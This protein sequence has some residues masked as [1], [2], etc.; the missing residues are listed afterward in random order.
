MMGQDESAESST[1]TGTVALVGRPNVGKS[2]LLNALLGEKIA[3]TTHKPQTTRRLLRGVL[4]RGDSQFVFVDTP[5]LL[6]RAK[7]LDSFMIEEALEAVRDVDVLALIAEAH[8]EKDADGVVRAV[9]DR[10]DVEALETIERE[11][12]EGQ[13]PV[14]LI[15]NKIDR[16]QDR[17]LLLP[18]IASWSERREFA[19]IIPISAMKRDG[20]SPLLDALA[21]HLPDGP[22]LFAPDTL[23]DAPEREI[24]AELIREKAMLE[25]GDELPYKVAVQIENFDESRR[26]DPRKPIITVEAVI[27]V[28]R[29]SQKRIV[30]GKGGERVK[31][32]GMRAR[33]ELERLLGAQVMLRVFVHVEPNWTTNDKGMRK[34]GYAR[35]R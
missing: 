20:L 32:I 22:F 8:L 33:K 26:D 28:E 12:G 11:N 15:L 31:T 23:T 34:V 4:T 30:V 18:L 10:R 17:G 1:K 25:L 27:H 3:A 6:Q 2:T 7:G 16:L 21:S 24:A 13:R 5:G 19:G 14:V 9:I 29:E 35:K